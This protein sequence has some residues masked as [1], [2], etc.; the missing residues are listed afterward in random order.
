VPNP[1]NGDK[2]AKWEKAW[3]AAGQLA[4]QTLMAV[5]ANLLAAWICEVF[6]WFTT[7]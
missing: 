3:N 1:V 2:P 6:N 7:T 5:V 4:N